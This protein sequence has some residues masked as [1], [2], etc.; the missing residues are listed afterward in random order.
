MSTIN[1]FATFFKTYNFFKI[2]GSLS[3]IV[4]MLNSVIYELRLFLTFFFILILHF[5]LMYGALGNGNWMLKGKFRDT[6]F[7]KD[8][9]NACNA[10]GEIVTRVVGTEPRV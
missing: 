2:Y 9:M 6:F 5:S 7:V 3:P 10:D 8:T 4:T 1:C